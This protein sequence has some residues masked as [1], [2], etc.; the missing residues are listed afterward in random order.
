MEL[1]L[2]KIVSILIL[3]GVGMYLGMGFDNIYDLKWIWC[4]INST[5]FGASAGI[6]QLRLEVLM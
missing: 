1:G 6:P 3:F 5:N 4:F 2:D